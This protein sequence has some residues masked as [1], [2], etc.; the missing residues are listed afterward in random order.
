MRTD[1]AV[2]YKPDKSQARNEEAGLDCDA[3]LE[4]ELLSLFGS[5]ATSFCPGRNFTEGQTIPWVAVVGLRGSQ[6][7]VAKK[8]A[9]QR[10]CDEQ[11]GKTKGRSGLAEHREPSVRASVPR[12]TRDGWERITHAGDWKWDGKCHV[13]PLN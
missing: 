8:I 11:L 12:S 7:G 13:Q 5:Q 10:D 6:C 1:T 3:E 4:Q 2:T 9:G